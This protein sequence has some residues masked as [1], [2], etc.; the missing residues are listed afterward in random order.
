MTTA[1]M[2]FA[3]L[4]ARQRAVYAAVDAATDK[5]YSLRRNTPESVEWALI[6]EACSR[7]A[8]RLHRIWRRHYM[9]KGWH[10]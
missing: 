9:P 2:P 1:P 6:G 5:H 8:Q 7:E 4:V 10:A 3:E